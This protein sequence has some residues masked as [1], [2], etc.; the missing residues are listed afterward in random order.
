MSEIVLAIIGWRGMDRRHAAIFNDTMKEFVIHNGFPGQF[1]SGGAKGADQIGEK[2]ADL[3]KIPKTILKP[4]W[5]PIVD[6]ATGERR[7][8]PNAA[9][10]RNTDIVGAATHV[11]AFP[12]RKGSGTQEAIAKAEE[13]GKPVVTVWID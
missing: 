4:E 2:W 1:V 10:K 13:M 8:D 11:I 7:Y 3:H 9:K 6:P 5:R 12:S